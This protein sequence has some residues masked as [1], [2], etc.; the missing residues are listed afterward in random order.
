[1][2]VAGP[3]CHYQK[4]FSC[5]LPSSEGGRATAA[6]G[7]LQQSERLPRTKEDQP[8]ANAICNQELKNRNRIRN[9]NTFKGNWQWKR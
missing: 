1:M 8:P 6:A 4:D 7:G 2:S 9:Q 5:D 3:M